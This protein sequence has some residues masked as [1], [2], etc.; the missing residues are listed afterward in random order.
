M[1]NQ[2][3]RKI[4][5]I[6]LITFILYLN[7]EIFIKQ[8]N[9]AISPIGYASRG[10]TNNYT[11]IEKFIN[12]FENSNNNVNEYESNFSCFP[13]EKK[14]YWKNEKNLQVKRLKEE[15]KNK[16]L[17]KISF[18]NKTDF[19]K[20]K[21]PKI[22]LIITLYNQGYYIE[23]LY[24]FIQQ[25]EL[26]D[27][28]IIF[29]DDCSSDNSSIIINQL[30]EYDK[31]IIYLKNQINKKQFYSINIGIINSRGQYILSIDPDDLL[32]NN[33]L[34]KAYE[35]A[36]YFNLDVIQFYMFSGWNLWITAKFKSGI[37][38]D[39]KNIRN[40][41]YF[42]V[43]R[44]LPDKLI[45]RTIYIKSINFMRKELINLDY[46][47][48]TDD[49]IFFGIIHF[50]RSYGFLE[51]IGYFYN[52]DR[53]RNRNDKLFNRESRTIKKNKNLKSLF[54]IMKYFILQSDN[55]TIEKNNIPYK[56]FKTKVKKHFISSINYINKDFEFYIEVLNLY[57]NCKHFGKNII[58]EINNLKKRIINQR[59]KI[60]MRKRKKKLK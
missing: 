10:D 54:N 41:F 40:I 39:N 29:V 24:A 28:E 48:H 12:S 57:L 20:R 19:Y 60:K 17:F 6:L 53:N 37:I 31:R 43:S 45:K 3:T 14:L 34:I 21:N 7:F 51:Q 32:I 2:I 9:T 18:E 5:Y 13:T 27:I 38:C 4:F 23:T 59:K 36:K 47:I 42:G 30:M 1:F 16:K 8:N 26:K 58:D 55:N 56:F 49:T 11:T 22:S 50:A 46:H 35:T 25:Q 52:K 44:N 15:I 33:I